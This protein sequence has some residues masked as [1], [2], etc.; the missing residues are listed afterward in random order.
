[1][2]RVWLVTVLGVLVTAGLVYRVAHAPGLYFG[3]ADVVFVMPSSEQIPNALGVYPGSLIATAGVIQR[4]VSKGPDTAHV[5]SDDVTIVDE[6]ET[7]AV[8]VT[9]PNSGGQWA[10]NFEKAALHVQA[11]DPD[12][13]VALDKLQSTVA[14]IRATLAAR[15]DAANV[16]AD[17]RIRT[18]VSPNPLRVDLLS[19]ERKRAIAASMALGLGATF[20]LMVLVD[21]RRRTRPPLRVPVR[22]LRRRPR[23]PLPT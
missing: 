21:R 5:V 18:E 11:V 1:M 13:A 22:A 17:R 8:S 7:S 16:A 14:T 10:N 4:E 19:G 2:L 9:L 3:S 6:G 23:S 15:E 20:A 12:Q